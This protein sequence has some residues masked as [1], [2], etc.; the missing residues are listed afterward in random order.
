MML[1]VLFID[2][3]VADRGLAGKLEGACRLFCVPGCELVSGFLRGF[4]PSLV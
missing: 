2:A 3:R 4:G 1:C